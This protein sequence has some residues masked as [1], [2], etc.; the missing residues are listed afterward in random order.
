METFKNSL[1][2]C[3]GA[4]LKVMSPT[5]LCW[6]TAS[7]VDVGGMAVEVE[8]PANIL[9]HFVAIKQMAVME[10]LRPCLLGCMPC[11]AFPQSPERVASV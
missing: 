11:S 9:L 5:L 3:M 1:L 10:N 8:S 2:T 6:P 7:D 4:A